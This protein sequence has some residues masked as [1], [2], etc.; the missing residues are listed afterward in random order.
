MHQSHS[1]PTQLLKRHKLRVT[2][3]REQVIGLFSASE[4]TLSL[5]DLESDLGDFDRV[6]L[7]RTLKAFE[8]K[9]LIHKVPTESQQLYYGLCSEN[10]GPDEHQHN[11]AHFNCTK[12]E[13][14]YCIETEAIRFGKKVIDGFKVEKAEILLEGICPNCKEKK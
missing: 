5:R 2:Q 7:Y 14:V 10:C 11:H 12:C 6:T 1:N 8:D 4:A 3:F 9:G 13:H